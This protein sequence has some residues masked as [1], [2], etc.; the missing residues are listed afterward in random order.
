MKWTKKQLEEISKAK[1]SI[2]QGYREA[3]GILDKNIHARKYEE[4]SSAGKMMKCLSETYLKKAGL[5]YT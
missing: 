1:K 3:K 4:R 5:D 2:W